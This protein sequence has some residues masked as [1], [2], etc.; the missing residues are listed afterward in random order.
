[1]EETLRH[2]SQHFSQQEVSS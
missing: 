2:F 1:V